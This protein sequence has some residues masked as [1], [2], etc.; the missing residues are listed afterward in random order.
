MASITCFVALAALPA[1][2]RV[3]QVQVFVSD[4]VAIALA[5]LVL[6]SLSTALALPYI[7]PAIG[8]EI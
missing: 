5:V 4:S 3:A 1:L 2:R 7:L 8:K 6:L